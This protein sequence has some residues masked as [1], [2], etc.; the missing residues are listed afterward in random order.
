MLIIRT[1]RCAFVK[2]LKVHSNESKNSY[3]KAKHKPVSVQEPRSFPQF[4]WASR[5]MMAAKNSLNLF[6][7]YLYM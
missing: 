5:I 6:I 4:S 3:G 2:K 1:K 7:L